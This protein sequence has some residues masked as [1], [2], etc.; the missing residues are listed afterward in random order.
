MFIQ[1]GKRRW[2]RHPFVEVPHLFEGCRPA[3]RLIGFHYFFHHHGPAIPLFC[4][5]ITTTRRF[6]ACPSN[7]ESGATSTLV[8]IAPGDK[9]LVNGMLACCSRKFVTFRA[10]SKL[11]LWLSARLPTFD[12]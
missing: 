5:I 1:T 10:R 12:A 4:R 7:V 3:F 11:S 6:S 9:I 8:P 2:V